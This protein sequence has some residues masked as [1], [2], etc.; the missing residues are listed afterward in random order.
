MAGYQ[1]QLTSEFAKAGKE[2]DDW[3]ED[4]KYEE[5][6]RAADRLEQEKTGYKDRMNQIVQNWTTTHA[7]T[8]GPDMG[9]APAFLDYIDLHA[10]RWIGMGLH[11]DQIRNMLPMMKD[12]WGE[13]TGRDPWEDMGNQVVGTM[14]EYMG[15]SEQT[16]SSSGHGTGTYEDTKDAE[17]KGFFKS[18]A[19]GFGF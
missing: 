5:Y 11:E 17:D 2:L 6:V 14:E 8:G 16:M 9:F 18:I 15:G 12:M 3:L 10:A 7:G 13:E 19:E 1:G 4:N